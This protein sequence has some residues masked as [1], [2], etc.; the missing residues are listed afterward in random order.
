MRPRVF[1]A[2]D[3]RQN[4]GEHEGA[5]GASMRPRVF[6]AEDRTRLD[7]LEDEVQASMRPRVFPAEDLPQPLERYGT[8]SELQ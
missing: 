5:E 8:T 6:P 3:H 7:W 4:D 2:E 1:P